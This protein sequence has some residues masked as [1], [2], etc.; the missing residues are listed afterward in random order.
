MAVGIR[1]KNNAVAVGP[2]NISRCA[3]SVSYL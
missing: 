3:F 1:V 2:L